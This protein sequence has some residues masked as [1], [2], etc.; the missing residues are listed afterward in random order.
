MTEQALLIPKAH[1]APVSSWASELPI[2]RVSKGVT[3]LCWRSRN[4]HHSRARLSL[5]PLEEV[6]VLRR[7]L[8]SY[9]PDYSLQAVE[10]PI[11]GIPVRIERKRHG[12][13]IGQ[14]DQSQWLPALEQMHEVRG[15]QRYPRPQM[16]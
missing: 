16:S 9:R 5:G 8:F 1:N 6:R 10:A 14:Y 12:S 13:Y 11:V 15:D 2:A 4:A 7:V 3:G